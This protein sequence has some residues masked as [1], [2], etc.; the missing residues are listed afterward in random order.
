MS[1]CSRLAVASEARGS[2]AMHLLFTTIYDYAI[3][4][5]VHFCFVTCVPP[6]VRVFRRY[7]FREYALPIRDA[8]V[9]QLHRLVLVLDDLAHLERVHSPFFPIAVKRG[10]GAVQRPWLESLFGQQVRGAMN[11]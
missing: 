3:T 11:G 1:V 4:K 2:V 10:I 9:G 5:G 7:G 8:A 6:L